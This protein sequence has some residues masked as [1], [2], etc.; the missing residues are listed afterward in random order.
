MTKTID[1]K[2]YELSERNY[3]GTTM[4]I[5]DCHQCAAVRD[6]QLCQALG[7]ACIGRGVWREVKV[8]VKQ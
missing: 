4:R 6:R 3:D 1:G 7:N 8:E 2:T 5:L